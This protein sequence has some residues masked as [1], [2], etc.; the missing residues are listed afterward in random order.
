MTHLCMLSM[1]SV[2]LY[3][4]CDTLILNTD[5]IDTCTNCLLVVLFLWQYSSA[6]DQNL[7]DP[8]SLTLLNPLVLMVPWCHASLMVLYNTKLG[9]YFQNTP[10]YCDNVVLSI[11]VVTK[12]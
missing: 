3:I 11:S 7:N 6:D 8:D 1:Y 4:T 12:L 10:P 5:N 9:N 2:Y